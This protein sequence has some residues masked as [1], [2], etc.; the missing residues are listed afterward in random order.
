MRQS[1]VVMLFLVLLLAGSV[2][3][4]ATNVTDD[5]I[6]TGAGGP[7]V[8]PVTL[9][10]PACANKGEVVY[11]GVS[12]PLVNP[13]IVKVILTEPTTGDPY[14][15]EAKVNKRSY[16]APSIGTSHFFYIDDVIQIV[17]TA[18]VKATVEGVGKATGTFVIPCPQ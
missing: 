14:L 6:V 16:N 8:G 9:T 2:T 12:Y 7:A 1:L 10:L 11:I 5:G 17:G 13:T 4:A 15:K 3:R 18:R